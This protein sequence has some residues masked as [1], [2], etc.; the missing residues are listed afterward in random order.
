MNKK[1]L[2]AII[3]IA[4]IIGGAYFV[5]KQKSTLSEEQISQLQ[6]YADPI[7]ENILQAINEDDYAKF[8]KNFTSEMKDTI[9]EDSFLEISAMITSAVGDYIS[10]ELTKAA[11]EGSYF[12]F[13][14][15]AKFTDEPDD[16][17]VKVVFEKLNGELEVAGLWFDSPKLRG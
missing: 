12:S 2:I 10:K 4:I 5:I 14:Y 13:Y 1:I 16:V 6:E 3:V 15:K 17:D 7:T 11:K 9:P 8:S